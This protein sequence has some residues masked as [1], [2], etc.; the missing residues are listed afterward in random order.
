V[1]SVVSNSS[2]ALQN[3]PNSGRN[4]GIHTFGSS[5]NCSKVVNASNNIRD[6]KAKYSKN[7]TTQINQARS[8]G[9]VAR[10]TSGKVSVARQNIGPAVRLNKK[11]I[12]DPNAPKKP[13]CAYFLFCQDERP[14]VKAEFPD[15]SVTDIAKEMGCRWKKVD[16]RR[17]EKYKERYEAARKVFKQDLMAYKLSATIT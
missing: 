14:K 10:K 1:G 7:N 9:K 3:S 6:T 11:H 5:A 8:T 13:L 4:I 2:N 16:S 12:K 17:K 15:H